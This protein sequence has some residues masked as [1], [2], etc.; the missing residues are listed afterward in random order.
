MYA[1]IILILVLAFSVLSAAE[2]TAQDNSPPET[3]EEAIGR[4]P[5]R[6]SFVDGQVSFFRPGADD[7]VRA[8]LNTPLS[9]G[10]QLYTGSPGNMEV[11]IGARAFVRGWANTQIG[12]ENHEPDFIQF[13]VTAGHASFDLRAL[14]PGLTVE[15][16]TPKAAF[17]IDRPGY[18]RVD[19]AGER[20][21]F[22]ARRGGRAIATPD[23]GTAFSIAPSEEVI[24]NGTSGPKI[25]S[26]SSPPLDSW[27]NWNYARTD[28][29][30]EAESARYVVPGIYGA[31]DL[32]RHGRWR[33][34][35]DYGPVWVPTGMPP[36]WAPYSTGAWIRDPY[37]G[38]T[39][40]DTAPWGWAPYHYGRWVHVGGFWGWSPGPTVVRPVYAPA[41]VAF[42][43]DPHIRVNVGIGGPTVGWVALSWGEPCV[44]WWGRPGFIHRPWWGGWGGPRIVNNVV[45]HRTAVVRV[46]EIHVYRNAGVRHGV[47]AIHKDRFGHGPIHTNRS[48][49][50]HAENLRPMHQGPDVKATPA[51]Y[52]PGAQRGIRPAEK[53][54]KRPVV[55]TRPPHSAS[56]QNAR[57]GHQPDATAARMHE[58][59]IVPAPQQPKSA[60]PL[61]RPPFGKS[62][63]ERRPETGRAQQPLPSRSEGLRRPAERPTDETRPSSDRPSVQQPR[64]AQRHQ[65]P[66][67]SDRSS[68]LDQ[69]DP[70]HATSPAPN[71]IETQ[72]SHQRKLPGEPASRLAPNR[73]QPAAPPQRLDGGGK[74][75]QRSEQH[76]APLQNQ[77]RPPGTPDSPPKGQRPGAPTAPPGGTQ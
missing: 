47:V 74:S 67:A 50:L 70:R 36:G 40:V 46:E 54:L 42:Y 16:A 12:L 31:S 1:R 26:F 35:P 57:P 39:W 63:I 58:P 19:I 24:I 17:T 66:E 56:E 29:L 4:T 60:E 2:L 45:V 72:R 23:D 3:D 69:T 22:I 20:T 7:W 37:Y 53:D 68:R 15:V 6:L 48:E 33:V 28:R 59:R 64:Q 61:P 32:D 27:D 55:A 14:D 51:A 71:S 52:M 10:D 34:V 8:Q 76:Q 38:W 49:R 30:L 43:G 77:R 11:Q 65:H 21:A 13:K 62:T 25:S 73:T 9:P 5:P 18:Y 44:P 41:L 75:P